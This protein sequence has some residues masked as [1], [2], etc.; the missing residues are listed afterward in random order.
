MRRLSI[1]LVVFFSLVSVASAD[2]DL[3]LIWIAENPA[4]TDVAL[5]C[6]DQDG[7]RVFYKTGQILNHGENTTN[8]KEIFT[9][10]SHLQNVVIKVVPTNAYLDNEEDCTDVEL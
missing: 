5:L 3:I 9:R 10:G 2:K 4:V 1:F 7:Y 8:P 6:L